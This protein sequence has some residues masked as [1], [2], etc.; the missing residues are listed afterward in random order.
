MKYIITRADLYT[1]DKHLPDATLVIEDGKIAQV[2][3]QGEVAASRAAQTVDATG[4]IVAPGMIDVHFHGA[5]GLDTM[6]AD[7]SSLHR[8]ARWCLEHGVTSFYPTTWSAS[9][10]DI[11]QALRA[12]A[13]AQADQRAARYSSATAASSTATGGQNH[14]GP[15]PGAHIMGAH[16]EGPYINLKYRGA[17]LAEM[18]RPPDP[19]EYLPWFDTGVVRL[20]TSAP[21]I[22]HGFDFIRAAVANDAVVAIGHSQATWAQVNRAAD[23]GATQAT[24]IFNGMVGLHHRKPG[25]VGGILTDKRIYAQMICDGVHLHPAVVRLVMDVKTPERTILITDAVRGTGLPD[26]EYEHKGQ[27]FTVVDGVAR[28]P[29]GG[30]SGSTLTLDQALR[31]ALQF[32]QRPLQQ[33]FATVSSVPAAAM[34]LAGKKGTIQPGADADLVFFNSGLAVQAVWL[35]GEP[36]FER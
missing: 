9:S 21:E 34:G 24:H 17:Q 28:T 1:P 36:V 11:L 26:G 8:L 6:D 29:E 16:L 5:L 19:A 23:L 18:I 7:P 22:V 12:V 14:A 20:V 25:T 35:M 33:L 2:A 10:E 27:R 31:N 15:I 3:A 13:A 30:L 32:T 4:M